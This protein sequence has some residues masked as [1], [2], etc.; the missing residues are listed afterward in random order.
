L[1]EKCPGIRMKRGE[2]KHILIKDNITRDV[3]SASGNIKTFD[4]LMH[5]AIT[6]KNTP[7]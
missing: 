5:R 1:F 3:D 2:R 6:K 7:F 4:T